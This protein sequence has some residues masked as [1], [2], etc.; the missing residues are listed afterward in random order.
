MP[1]PGSPS[2]FGRFGTALG[3]GAAI[4]GAA[5]VA[6]KALGLAQRA[7]QARKF[8]DNYRDMLAANPD[9]GK[10]DAQK[11]MGRFR[12]LHKFGPDVASDPVVAGSWI[13]QTLEFPVITPTV[14]REVVDVQAR[15]RQLQE[16]PGARGPA[17]R[18]GEHLSKAMLTRMPID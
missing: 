16:E 3:Q 13:R 17:S 11:V 15:T 5:L 18:F 10:E 4:A 8:S 7:W 12:I 14:L 1:I 2:M 6:E 9:L